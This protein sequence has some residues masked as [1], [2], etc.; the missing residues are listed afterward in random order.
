MITARAHYPLVTYALI[1][2]TSWSSFFS[3]AAGMPLRNGPVPAQFTKPSGE[4]ITLLPP[5]SCAGWLHLIGNMVYPWI[6]GDV[7]DCLAWPVHSLLP[8]VRPGDFS[9]LFFSQS[10]IPNLMRFR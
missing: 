10:N 6:F 9:Q 7:E 3:W 2:S 4:F 8:A 5:C 1:A